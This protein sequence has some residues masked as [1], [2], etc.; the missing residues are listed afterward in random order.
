MGLSP[1]GGIMLAGVAAIAVFVLT[2]PLLH[3]SQRPDPGCISCARLEREITSRLDGLRELEST[4]AESIKREIISFLRDNHTAAQHH[5]PAPDWTAPL[6]P[7]LPCP[8]NEGKYVTVT[9]MLAGYGDRLKAMTNAYV[10]A[11]L[12]GR[13]LVV[14]DGQLFDNAHS[15]EQG[16]CRWREPMPPAPGGRERW[17]LSVVN[18]RQNG[19]FYRK[20]FRSHDGAA[21]WDIE[22]NMVFSDE[23]LVNPDFAASPALP[24]L[25]RAHARGK[26]FH[27]ALRSLF[28]LSQGMEAELKTALAEH[29]P[30]GS[31][32]LIGLHIRA[33]DW[34]MGARRRRRR[35]RSH[36]PSALEEGAE[37]EGASFRTTHPQDYRMAPE[38]SYPCF[39][40]EGLALWEE[41]PDAERARYPGGP[42]FFVS[43]DYPSGARR[44]VEQFGR[45][46]WSAFESGRGAVRH[47]E[48]GGDHSRTYFDWWMLTKARRLVITVSGYSETA[49][50]YRC[51][52]TSFFVN[53]PTLKNHNDFAPRKCVHHFIR[54]RGDGLCVPEADDDFL[55]EYL[56]HRYT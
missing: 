52:S 25:L 37:E 31:R 33:G 18:V 45:A 19:P 4:S 32:Y 40:A 42:L 20:D 12:T 44:L 24:V 8:S 35:R 36:A 2:Q 6:A 49:A 14:P 10:V 17:D 22:S 51:V 11:L 28:T 38:E 43:S 26:L 1:L 54:M 23:L 50:K 13:G 7:L 39:V 46:G 29:D 27:L 30:D 9:K 47:M 16:A 48:S 15:L 56:Y 21:V 34:K 53:H 3:P 41:L 5:E 55:F